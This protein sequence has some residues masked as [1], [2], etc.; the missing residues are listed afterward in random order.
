MLNWPK[1]SD[2][3]FVKFQRKYVMLKWTRCAKVNFK[4][5][6]ILIII[7]VAIGVSLFAARQARRRILSKIDFQA[8]NAAFEKED[9]QTACRHFREYLG[10]NPDDIEI[11]KK[12]AKAGLSIRPQNPNNINR[13]I[14]TYRQIM[15][16]DPQEMSTYDMLAKLYM[17]IG[18]YEELAYI[19]RTKINHDENDPKARLWLGEALQK[20]KKPEEAKD[21]L[22]NLIV[23][24]QKK[25]PEKHPEY[26][27]ACI[28][29]SQ[30]ILEED[31]Y[32][33]ANT[34]ETNA[35]KMLN[36]AVNYDKNSVEALFARAQFN[37]QRANIPGTNKKDKDNWLRLALKDLEKID[38]SGTNNPR[39]HLFL[40]SEWL[41][42]GELERA[43]DELK[44]AENLPQEKIEEHFFDLKEWTITKFLFASELA[45]RKRSINECTSLADDILN[46]FKDERE[47][48]RVLP[49]AIHLYVTAGKAPNARQCLVDYIDILY[50]Q[51]G[52]IESIEE[53]AYLRAIVAMAED[54][55]Y[56]VID[57]LQP[58]IMGNDSRPEFWRLLAEAFSKTDQTRRAI[59]A[60]TKYLRL[61]P[62]DAEMRQQLTKE[63]L[64]LRDW[65][66]ALRAAKLGES[67]DPK[68]IIPKLLR[69]EASVNIVAEQQ[70]LKSVIR[71]ALTDETE[72]LAKLREEDPNNV[73]IRILQAIVADLLDDPNKAEEELIRAIEECEESLQAEMQL[74]RFYY[75]TKRM[76]EAIS[77]CK[78]ACEN[79]SEVAEPWLTLS[80]LYVA[81]KDYD[82]VR[83]NLK[84]AYDIVVGKWEKR[85]IS[86]RLALLEL[87]YENEASGI[88]TLNEIA[89]QDKREI[90]AR[91]LLLRIPKVQKDQVK[92]Q[93]LIDELKKAEGETGLMWRL[94][95][96][97]NWL[98]SNE[99]RSKQQDIESN[100]QYCID[101]DPEWSEP[102]I[103]LGQMYERLQNTGRA[104][105][106]YRQALVRNPSA[107]DIMDKLVTLLEKQGRFSEAEK[108]LQ[109]SETNPRYTSARYTL[110][111]LRAGATSKAINELKARISNDDKDA[112][113]RILLAR[114]IYWQDKDVDQALRYLNEAEAITSGSIAITAARVSILRAEDRTEEA[115]QIL[116]DYVTAQNDFNAYWMRA[117][118]KTQE[119]DLQNAEEDYRKLTTF[120]K[121]GAKGYELLSNFYVRCEKFDKAIETI[122]EG[123]NAYPEEDLILK[124]RLMMTLFLQSSEQNQQR[125]LEI[126][127]ELEE[128]LPQDPELMKMRAI[129][130]L[131]ES[132]PQSLKAARTKLE[133]VIK[134]EPTAVDAHLMLIGIAMQEQDYETARNIAIRAIGS[135]P[136][137]MA[138]LEARSKIELKLD[139]VPMAAQL[140]QVVL[141]NDPN[142]IE[143][144]D[145]LVAAALNSENY[146]LLE[147]V[148]EIIES[149]IG[150]NPKDE[151]LLISRARILVAMDLPKIAIP[152]LEAYCLTKEG[153]KSVEA[154]VTLADLYR[155]SKEMNIA[156]QWIEKA[157][158]IDP[159]SQ[160]VIHARFLWLVEQNIFEELKGIS[161]VYLS[162]KDQNPTLLFKAATILATLDSMVLRKEGTRL[163]EHAVTLSPTLVKERLI[164]ASTLY[165]TGNVEDAENIY[166]E[167]LEKYPN[168]VQILND[169][170]WILQEHYHRYAEALELANRAIQIEP[171]NLNVLDT[172]GTILSNLP[173]RLADARSDFEKLVVLSES[174]TRQRAMA[175][176]QLGRICSQLNNLEQAKQ[177]LKNA[178][179]IDQKIDE[180]IFTPEEI[181]EI[182]K[183]LQRNGV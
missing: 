13:V 57:T 130:L 4:V 21:V 113:S 139:N 176:L 68:D 161:T 40:T 48:V 81:N 11:L 60:L 132:T 109:Q 118:Y 6:I 128:R 122:E 77:T 56:A 146:N 115:Q 106:I 43:A 15:R 89:A 164:Y 102:P 14:A 34:P 62:Q 156:K 80:D 74:T 69:I 145:V 154:I 114:L 42:H 70:Q 104:E 103:L 36:A 67:L 44:T 172:R 63:Y 167:L 50:S 66:K 163:Y 108:T 173:N 112:N 59:R 37:R 151:K 177:H 96:A 75:R 29:M 10:R 16:V 169:L 101:Q 51:Q 133:N 95:Q 179:E 28:L 83:N 3:K 123:L 165:Q 73:D 82:F 158:E 131:N 78:S 20:L 125:A 100:L 160:V 119:N 39:I 65:S 1:I 99:W 124:R 170:A 142:N 93:Q 45:I 147:E 121:Q 129:Q 137:N 116:D 79:H 33:D 107:T 88:N 120:P 152:E 86:M 54:D 138:L 126:L 166:R 17:G 31:S 183:I 49:T 26:V 53:L 38:T 87:T 159:K 153:S 92:V 30:I 9:W 8:G 64:K 19:A 61:R 178:L 168:K 174:D 144:I 22:N 141:Q 71:K 76:D 85:S 91:T 58:V 55:S 46:T 24:I 97:A 84:Q 148:R 47:Q 136:Q 182:T 140:A 7:T 32:E 25:L 23:D 127:A 149:S 52:Q 157:E 41:A 180:D 98:A 12:Y 134:L 162:A 94:H 27:R 110:L 2:G 5:L 143:A 117:V 105:N 171:V 175:L 135:N 72:E 181:S 90:R 111:S 150:S 155:I 35:E 18:N